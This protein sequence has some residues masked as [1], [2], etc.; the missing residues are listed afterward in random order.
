MKNTLTF[1][2]LLGTG[3]ILICLTIPAIAYALSQTYGGWTGYGV[4]IWTTYFI[5]LAW[6]FGYFRVGRK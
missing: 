2:F 6:Y 4:I 1:L 5:L 3:A